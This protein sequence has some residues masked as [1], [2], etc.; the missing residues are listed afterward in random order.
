MA[1][2]FTVQKTI[3]APIKRLYES[4]SKAK[5]LSTWFTTKHKHSFKPGGKYKNA[6]NDEGTYIEIIP[7]R[8]IRFT[9]DN[10]KHCPGTEVCIRFFKTGKNKSLVKLTHSKLASQA[11][12]NDMKAGWNWALA[13]LKLYVEKGK[14]VSFENWYKEKYNT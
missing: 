5:E 3:N 13:C 1:Y 2:S 4:F 8:L 12:V 6:D 7:D 14:L 9:W 10:V 11:H